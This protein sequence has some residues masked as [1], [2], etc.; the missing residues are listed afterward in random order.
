MK[1]KDN[2]TQPL[3]PLARVALFFI[4]LNMV[5]K[6]EIRPKAQDAFARF[7]SVITYF[8]LSVAF[9]KEETV[10]L[11][12][13]EKSRYKKPKNFYLVWLLYIF[14]PLVILIFVLWIITGISHLPQ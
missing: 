1:D 10:A 11:M 5:F 8:Y 4:G 7:F 12:A 14:V 2:K 3:N 9:S 13:E 6:G